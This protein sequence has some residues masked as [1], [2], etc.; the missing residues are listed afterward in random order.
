MGS[1]GTLGIA[2]KAIIKLIGLPRAKSYL[3]VLF[4]EQKNAIGV[5]PVIMSNS[6]LPSG[7]EFMDRL[8]VQ[9]SC[10]YLNESLPH[11]Q[12]GTM[13][14]IEVDGQ[15]AEQAESDIISIGELCESHGA[16]E[17]YVAEDTNTMERIWSVRRN[18]AEAFKVYSPVQ[19]LE[20]IVVPIASIADEIP[21]L[22][23]ISENMP[24]W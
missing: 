2:T 9:T 1:K 13:L 3:L 14:L 11:E 12:A 20:D 15:T 10:R 16:I 24:R 17:V 21:E 23:R 6:I 4:H 18:I 19:S 8:S 7:I 5:V 22:K